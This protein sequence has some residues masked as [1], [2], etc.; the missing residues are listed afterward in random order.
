MMQAEDG[1]SNPLSGELALVTGSG[2][3]DIGR[4]IAVSLA[5]RGADV[6]ILDKGLQRVNRVAE[7]I[8]RRFRVKVYPYDF[9]LMHIESIPSL[10]ASI[11]RSAGSISIL[12]NNAAVTD[13]TPVHEST[14]ESWDNIFTVNLKCPWLLTK[15]IV[16]GMIRARRGA[17]VNISSVASRIPGWSE[18]IYGASKAALESLTRD[19]AHELASFGIRCNAVAPGIV[20]SY[21]VN[22]HPEKYASA[23]ERSPMGRLPTPQDIANLVSYLVSPAASGITG[24]VVRVDCG[25]FMSA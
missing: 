23:V 10:I 8:A 15:A 20:S 7:E 9:D 11:E 2:G 17:V 25:M 12:I 4:A 21:F 5:E 18:G 22:K 6:I 16:P 1:C 14:S 13:I 24:E 3:R 19:Q